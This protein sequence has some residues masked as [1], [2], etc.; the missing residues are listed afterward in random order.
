[1]LQFLLAGLHPG[2]ELVIVANFVRIDALNTVAFGQGYQTFVVEYHL[3]LI[4][5]RY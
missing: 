2:V 1:M 3:D 4:A 5:E